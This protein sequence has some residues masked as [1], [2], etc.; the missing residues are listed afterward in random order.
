LRPLELLVFV[1]VDAI[2]AILGVVVAVGETQTR[3]VLVQLQ[4][5]T[6]LVCFSP[7]VG[8]A[9]DENHRIFVLVD[10]P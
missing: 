9:V 3:A 5:A 10:K 4:L 6:I 2:A 1:G 7:V 8:L